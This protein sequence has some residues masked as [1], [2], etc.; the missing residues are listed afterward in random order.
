MT[1]KG[2]IKYHWG[3][4][5]KAKLGIAQKIPIIYLEEDYL[6]DPRVSVI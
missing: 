6:A 3:E 4:S 1:K 2:Q 5:W